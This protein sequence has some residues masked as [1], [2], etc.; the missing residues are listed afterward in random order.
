[1]PTDVADKRWRDPLWWPL[2][3]G[4][5]FSVPAGQILSKWMQPDLANGLGFFV[6]WMAVCIAWSF[7]PPV[8]NWSLARWTVAAAA[9]ALAGA[10]L[11]SLF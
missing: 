5:F 8:P 6:A 1:M 4:G 9:G 10:G 11:A 7:R 2:V 3:L